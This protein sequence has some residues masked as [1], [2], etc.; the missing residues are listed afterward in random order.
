MRRWYPTH[1]EVKL[2]HGWGTRQ[3]AGD[4]LMPLLTLL[5]QPLECKGRIRTRVR[6]GSTVSNAP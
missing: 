3:E 1:D 6:V 5:C 2:L 4:T